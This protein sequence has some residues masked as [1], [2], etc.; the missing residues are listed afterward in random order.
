MPMDDDR[1]SADVATVLGVAKRA[2]G[3]A[4]AVE[5]LRLIAERSATVGDD[6]LASVALDALDR[7]DPKP[8]VP[9]GEDAA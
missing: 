6:W 2:A 3:R 4:W 1:G 9:H 5:L 8:Q 7:L